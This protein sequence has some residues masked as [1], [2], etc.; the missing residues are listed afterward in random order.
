ML[1]LARKLGQSIVIGD[2]IVVTVL[3]IDPYGGVRLGIVAP[4][5]VRIV[6][7]ELLKAIA[8]EN[9]AAARSA[10]TAGLEGVAEPRRNRHELSRLESRVSQ[11]EPDRDG[12]GPRCTQGSRA[13]T[14]PGAVLR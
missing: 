13:S 7:D 10:T 9:E 3:A 6:R 1:V 11:P 5:D 4:R 8:T 14:S 2:D 12:E